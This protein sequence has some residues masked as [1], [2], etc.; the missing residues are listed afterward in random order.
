MLELQEI[1]VWS[2]REEDPLEEDMA[3][4]SSILA[5]KILWAD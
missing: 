2:L 3:T 4:Y 5:G 1:W